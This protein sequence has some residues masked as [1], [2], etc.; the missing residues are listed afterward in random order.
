MRDGLCVSG[1]G[2]V[3]CRRFGRVVPARLWAEA[4]GAAEAESGVSGWEHCAWVGRGQ[5]LSSFA[6]WR[7]GSGGDAISEVGEP[8]SWMR[9]VEPR[10]GTE[11]CVVAGVGV[12]EGLYELAW[13]S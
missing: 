1:C 5:C 13:V 9:E 10:R 7:V 8:L 6:V 4:E 12:L 2:G 3:A 11:W